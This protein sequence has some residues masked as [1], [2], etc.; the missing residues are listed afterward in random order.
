MHCV[1]PDHDG[2]AGT[3]AGAG[4]D[5]DP[6]SGT[7]VEVR[8]SRQRQQ[9]TRMRTRTWACMLAAV[10]LFWLGARG[11]STR[12]ARCAHCSEPARCAR[13]HT[14][15]H[16]GTRRHTQAHACSRLA[17]RSVTHTPFL[18]FVPALPRLAMLALQVG[19]VTTCGGTQFRD[20]PEGAPCQF[21][22]EY[23]SELHTACIGGKDT[24]GDNGRPW[25][26]TDPVHLQR[27]Y[28]A[29]DT[30]SWGNCDC[31]WERADGALAAATEGAST[32]AAAAAAVTPK[33]RFASSA[34]STIAEST[35]AEAPPTT[36]TQDPRTTAEEATTYTEVPRERDEAGE[37]QCQARV[38][39]AS[40]FCAA[41]AELHTADVGVSPSYT[42][43]KCH[44]FAV[45]GAAPLFLTAHAVCGA[46]T[47]RVCSWQPNPSSLMCKL[48]KLP[49]CLYVTIML[50][51]P[52]CAQCSLRTC[53]AADGVLAEC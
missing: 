6:F 26:L 15:A 31:S 14:H 24:D 3:G 19:P 25:C 29:N 4:D 47:W 28:Q 38:G 42:A 8:Q 44:E 35:F 9:P 37:H 50:T 30:A 2:G 21:P 13:M 51:H 7:E 32:T 18:T 5:P 33:R 39:L 46:N 52:L 16:S 49:C 20:T 12:A 27:L 1:D 48:L 17:S 36:Y 41:G 53:A 22:F 23:E 34:A 40:G 10:H 43:Q 45:P 11:T